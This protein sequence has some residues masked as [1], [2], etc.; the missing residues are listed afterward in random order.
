MEHNP[1]LVAPPGYNESEFRDPTTAW[2]GP[3]GFWRLIVGAN[4]GIRGIIGTALLFKSKDFYNWEFA[5]R[6]LHSV[7]GTG[8]W[9]CPDFYPVLME[10]MQGLESS[11]KQQPRGS[12]RT[13]QDI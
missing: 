10:G 9:E 11:R 6:P 12:Y 13:L 5:G 4:A 1:V 2:Q 8:M 7:V 3:D